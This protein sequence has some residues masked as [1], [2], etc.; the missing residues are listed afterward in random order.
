MAPRDSPWEG[1][2]VRWASEGTQRE[3]KAVIT[4]IDDELTRTLMDCIKRY[5][6]QGMSEAEIEQR[7]NEIAASAAAHELDGKDESPE[8]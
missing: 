1:S 8:M 3:G 2:G 4:T 6:A 7:V 5:R